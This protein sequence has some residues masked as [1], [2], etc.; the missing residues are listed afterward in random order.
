MNLDRDAAVRGRGG[1]VSS[2]LVHPIYRE[3]LILAA[4][5]LVNATDAA[6]LRRSH[7]VARRVSLPANGRQAVKILCGAGLR[8]QFH[9][10][11]TKFG[12]HASAG[13]PNSFSRFAGMFDAA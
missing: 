3:V 13:G 12:A 9:L 6:I 1:N 5:R 8:P 11:D 4:I 2:P 7:A 10:P